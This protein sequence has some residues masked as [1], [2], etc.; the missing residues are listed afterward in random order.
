MFTTPLQLLATLSSSQGT[1]GRQQ[2]NVLLIITSFF[3]AG[4]GG[5]R[6][7]TVEEGGAVGGLVEPSL[8]ASWLHPSG[9]LL[10]RY[11]SSSGE[12]EI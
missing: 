10:P 4:G 11:S 6:E 1:L 9:V 7:G 5:G 12:S 2:L 3:F 8:A